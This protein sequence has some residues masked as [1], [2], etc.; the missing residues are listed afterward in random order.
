MKLEFVGETPFLK[1][2]KSNR[3]SFRVEIDTGKYSWEQIKDI[4][5]L[6][7]GTYKVTIETIE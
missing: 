5:N 1:T 7:E 2:F 4:P 3:D 6:P